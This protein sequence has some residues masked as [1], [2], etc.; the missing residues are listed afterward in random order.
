M[1]K[2]TIELL[3]GGDKSRAR[4]LGKAYIGRVSGSGEMATYEVLVSGTDLMGDC[5]T[6]ISDYPR[7]SS[8][9]WD[10]VL[11]SAKV[12]LLL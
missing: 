11:R 1:I 7:N 8:S 6:T 12:Q 4:T 3:P 5:W 9:I 2:V 10:L